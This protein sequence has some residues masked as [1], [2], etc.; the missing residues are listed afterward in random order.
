MFENGTETVAEINV[1]ER[2]GNGNENKCLRRVWKRNA[3]RKNGKNPN[4][5]YNQAKYV[6]N[7]YIEQLSEGGSAL[8]T[9]VS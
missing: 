1:Q 4:T 9:A 8:L 3:N 5:E 6:L 2:H 7:A